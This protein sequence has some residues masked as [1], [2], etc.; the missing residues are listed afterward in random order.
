MEAAIIAYGNTYLLSH[1]HGGDASYDPAKVV[2]RT[3]WR[4]TFLQA[5]SN[6]QTVYKVMYAD[7]T[8][9]EEGHKHYF[10]VDE[11][12]DG[13]TADTVGSGDLHYHDIEAYEVGSPISDSDTLVDHTHTLPISAD[14]ED[15][16]ETGDTYQIYI[17]Q[18][19]YNG[20]N[21]SV[22]ANRNTISFSDDVTVKT[23]DSS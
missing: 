13:V 9:V 3:D 18:V 7:P 11:E 14:D 6:T 22:D 16:W 21:A 8:S 2:L 15:P 1:R 19:A 23:E 4:Q 5:S 12:G 10:V 20:P 17:N